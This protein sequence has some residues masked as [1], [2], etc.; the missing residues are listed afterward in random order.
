MRILFELIAKHS[1]NP[2]GVEKLVA[3]LRPEGF[4]EE[5]I[6]AEVI[7]A[8]LRLN[9]VERSD[10]D[11]TIIANTLRRNTAELRRLQTDR[12]LKAEFH[13]DLPGLISAKDVM[14]LRRHAAKNE[15]TQIR[16]NEP[17]SQADAATL[18][19]RIEVEQAQ[20]LEKLKKRTHSAAGSS[21][22]EPAKPAG[23]P[24]NAPCPCKS[25]DKYKRCC[26]SGAPPQYNLSPQGAGG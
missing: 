5:T 1:M 14:R 21:H 8:T 24:R 23:V 6:A 7:W 13:L 22:S 4:L 10:A 18:S 25:G 16:K 12:H 15:K 17:I 26:G 2:E 20:L 19:R 3:T 9:Q 11:R